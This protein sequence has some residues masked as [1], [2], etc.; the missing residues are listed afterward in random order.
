MEGFKNMKNSFADDAIQ[1]WEP[2]RLVKA[3]SDVIGSGYLTNKSSTFCLAALQ[4]L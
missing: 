3:W 4:A 1:D 2:M